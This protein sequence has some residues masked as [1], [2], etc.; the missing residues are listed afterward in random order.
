MPVPLS[1]VFTG[2]WEALQFPTSSLRDSFAV[3]L[4]ASGFVM[5]RHMPVDFT[6]TTLDARVVSPPT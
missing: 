6:I 1:W 3:D 4:S 2:Q 5:P